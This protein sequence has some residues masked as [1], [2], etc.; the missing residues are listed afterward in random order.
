MGETVDRS[1]A[2]DVTERTRD[3]PVHQSI[4]AWVKQQ[5][6]GV[7]HASVAFD[8]HEHLT[9]CGAILKAG[10]RGQ[11]DDSQ[12]DPED[13]PSGAWFCEHCIDPPVLDG[14]DDG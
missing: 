13:A 4:G 8:G 3:D 12:I 1:R 9:R 10:V 2:I 11:V 6:T 14:D 5:K 7:Y